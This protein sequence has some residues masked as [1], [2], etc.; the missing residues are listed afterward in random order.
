MKCIRIGYRLI[1]FLSLTVILWASVEGCI[2]GTVTDPA[3][4]V[5]RGAS[6]TAINTANNIE[7]TM[8][9]GPKGT[10][11]FQELPVGNYEIRVD[12]PNFK[13]YRRLGVV[14]NTNSAL[15]LDNQLSVG[16]RTETIIVEESPTHIDTADTQI[17]EVVGGTKMT[18]VPLNGRSFTDLLALQPGV[19]P[20]TSITSHSINAAGASLLNPSGNLN[21]GTISINGQREYANGFMVND[22]DTV[23]RFTMGAAVDPN[24]DSIAEFRIL[25]GNFDAEYGNYSGGRISVVTKSGASGFHGTA[26]E[27]LRNTKLDASNFISGQLGIH[28]QNQLGGLF[29]GPIVKNRIFFFSDYQATRLKQGVDTGLVQVPSLQAR[30]GDFS[31]VAN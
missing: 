31:D 10:Y 24:L 9:T 16:G 15:L 20:L 23:E 13:P 17:G 3:G 5:V 30:A 21:P 11:S 19:A 29:G 25:T 14:L 4:A 28:R 12:A 26:F 22:A 1:T 18:A 6:V 2:S 8:T 7:R 27:F